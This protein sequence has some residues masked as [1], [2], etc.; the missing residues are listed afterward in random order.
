M[1]ISSYILTLL[2]LALSTADGALP[3]PIQLS[4][5]VLEEIQQQSNTRRTSL[6]SRR[7]VLEQQTEEEIQMHAEVL[8]AEPCLTALG[9]LGI[10][11]ADELLSVNPENI[12]QKLNEENCDMNTGICDYSRFK[13]EVEAACD[14]AGGKVILTDSLKCKE[15]L[16]YGDVD[17]L[18]KNIPLCYPQVCPDDANYFRMQGMFLD[19]YFLAFKKEHEGKGKEPVTALDKSMAKVLDT[20]IFGASTKQQ[21]DSGTKLNE[22]EEV[23]LDY[24]HTPIPN[25]EEEAEPDNTHNP[26]PNEEEEAES[27]SEIM[28]EDFANPTNDWTTLND[29]VMG[30]KS[31]SSLSIND[32]VAH[33]EGYCAIVPFLKA[34]GFIT[35]VTGRY[36]QGPAVFPDVSTCSSLKVVLRSDVRYNGY[37]L[38]FGA[39]KGRGHAMGYKTPLTSVPMEE[40][41]NMILDFSDFSSSWDDA[42]GKTAVACADDRQYC[43]TI[44]SLQDMKTISFWGEGVEGDVKLYIK[45]ISAVGC[46]SS[47][48]ENYSMGY[49]PVTNGQEWGGSEHGDASGEASWHK[50]DHGASHSHEYGGKGGEEYEHHGEYSH[51]DHGYDHEAAPEAATTTSIGSPGFSMGTY[52]FIALAA[53]GGSLLGGVALGKIKRGFGICSQYLYGPVAIGNEGLHSP[54]LKGGVGE[55]C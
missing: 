23:E 48:D 36:D 9:L 13:D 38:S 14:K 11:D 44:S 21:C 55:Q 43:P 39:A 27:D 7:Q 35:M 28:I 3:N 53:F 54:H 1:R 24:T 29:P 26:I 32:G 31:E 22:E 25:E 8:A 17:E 50:N 15:D 40:Y 20:W 37:Y 46:D 4:Q 19:D 51:G 52:I 42:T 49:G 34:P 2:T 45:S 16:G 18:Y 41:G 30:G 47:V 6:R 5:H 33:F 10:R 12:L